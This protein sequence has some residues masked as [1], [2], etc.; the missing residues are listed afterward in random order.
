MWGEAMPT[1]NS[2]KC[3]SRQILAQLPVDKREALAVLCFVTELVEAADAV[4]QDRRPDLRVVR[5]AGSS[6]ASNARS[7]ST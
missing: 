5:A 4:F 1:D 2:L 7:T 6:A 3:L